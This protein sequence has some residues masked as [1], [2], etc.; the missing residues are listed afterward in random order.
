MVQYS[1]LR[2]IVQ[3]VLYL[4]RVEFVAE[5]LFFCPGG[6]VLLWAPTLEVSFSG[7][8]LVFNFQNSESLK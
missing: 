6:G 2:F 8:A 7:D 4:A 3:A 5:L 1:E